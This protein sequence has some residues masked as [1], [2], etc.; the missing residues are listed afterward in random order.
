MSLTLADL[1][2]EVHLIF[3][4]P[5][6][7]SKSHGLANLEIDGRLIVHHPPDL[8]GG[9]RT[10]LITVGRS[11]RAA[12]SRELLDI[13]PQVVHIADEEDHGLAA[14]PGVIV[15]QSAAVCPTALRADAVVLPDGRF[16][17]RLG[18]PVIAPGVPPV[19][20]GSPVDDG[21]DPD[22]SQAHW[23]LLV[24]LASIDQ[25]R[26][27]RRLRLDSGHPAISRPRIRSTRSPA[28]SY[29]G[30]V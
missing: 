28:P 26:R 4:P 29:S 30:V 13:A 20:A 12:I 25:L 17:D 23:R 18:R 11:R 5:R 22:S 27:N 14:P 21:L 6:D 19:P 2:H 16:L 9:W 24:Y 8:P 7:H 3:A 15:L 10:G 1:G